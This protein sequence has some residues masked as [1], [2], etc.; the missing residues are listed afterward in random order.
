M[1]IPYL[2]Y[3]FK[4]R[5]GQRF[6]LVVCI[7]ACVAGFPVRA[8]PSAELVGGVTAYNRGDFATARALLQSAAGRGE[9]EAMVNLGYMYAR[10][11][12]GRQDST[13]ALELYRRAAAAGDGE[14]MNAVGFRFNF[15]PKPDY[16]NAI[17]WYCRAIA[18]GNQRA[19]NNLAI[20]FHNG[21]GVKKDLDEARYLWRQS[22][23]RG[24]L[25]AQTNV[26]SDMAADATLPESER[27]AGME[28]VRDA[29]RQGGILA[30]DWL[31]KVGDAE[32]F[33]PGTINELTMKLEARDPIPGAS[34]AC[35]DL[36]S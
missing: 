4:L 3:N 10:G 26:G 15:A 1:R 13:F 21:Q 36:I 7:L 8:D 27:Q 17:R 5:K 24:D 25:N 20:L 22:A 14:G 29:A 11:Q 30:Q 32:T 12:G 35:G 18:R 34:K 31:R 16:P 23:A 33:P 6:Q 28:M 9:A 2:A 19:L